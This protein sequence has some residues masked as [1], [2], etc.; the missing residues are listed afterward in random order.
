MYVRLATKNVIPIS[1]RI[2]FTKIMKKN[3]PLL[4]VFSFRPKNVH[5]IK[6]NAV[7]CLFL[8]NVAPS[9][10]VVGFILNNSHMLMVESIAF[11]AP[12]KSRVLIILCKA[13]DFCLFIG[14]PDEI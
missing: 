5:F 12:Y 9:K 3:L 10:R 13:D 11:Y 14:L 8:K 4:M 1:R 6:K 2:P 7:L